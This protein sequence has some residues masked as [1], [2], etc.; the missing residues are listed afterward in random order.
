MCCCFVC[1]ELRFIA[2]GG[3]AVVSLTMSS[4]ILLELKEP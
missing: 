3:D 4:M 1:I 2:S